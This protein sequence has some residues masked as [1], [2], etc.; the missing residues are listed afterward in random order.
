MTIRNEPITPFERSEFT[1][2]VLN[3][4]SRIISFFGHKIPFRIVAK[5][6]VV[7]KIILDVS[8]LT[9]H[10]MRHLRHSLD[11]YFDAVDKKAIS[12]FI[13][14]GELLILKPENIEMYF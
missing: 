7:D 3:E 6:G 10:E 5:N 11:D 8:Y 4:C 9:L 2:K 1:T 14:D 12:G 13:F